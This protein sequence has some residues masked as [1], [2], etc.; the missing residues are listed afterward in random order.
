MPRLRVAYH[1]ACSLQH[2]QKIVAPP[3]EL[4]AAAGF[5][6]VEVPEAHIC[7]GSAG[8]Y[9]LLRPELADQLRERKGANIKSIEPE[10]V[11]AG[12]IGCI[13]QIAVR[14]RRPGGAHGGA[15]G[16]GYGR[17]EARGDGRLYRTIS[18][19]LRLFLSRS[20]RLEISKRLPS[21]SIIS[22]RKSPSHWAFSV[23]F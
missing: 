17:T 22:K 14:G 21:T 1:D 13:E 2:G 15:A 16:L 10:L 9:N 11:A 18:T 5:E 12:N 23:T 19:R 20:L 7:C 3:R 6:V 4:L 8:T